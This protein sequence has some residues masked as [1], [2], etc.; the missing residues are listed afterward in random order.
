MF[1]VSREM[2][3]MQTDI[4]RDGIEAAQEQV[5]TVTEYFLIAPRSAVDLHPQRIADEV[6]ARISAALLDFVEQ[7]RL[8]GADRRCARADVIGV[9]QREFPLEKLLHPALRQAEQ[10][11]KNGYR[12]G[13]RELLD[14]VDFAAILEF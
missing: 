4:G 14:E 2:V 1:G 8:D 13:D 6:S 5:E 11:Q 3:K 12:I 10:I 7:Q 9:Q